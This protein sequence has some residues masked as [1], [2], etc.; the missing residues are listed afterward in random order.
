MP[1]P[2]PF[3]YRLPISLNNHLQYPK[4][5][6]LLTLIIVLLCT[7]CICTFST[8]PP[9]PTSLLVRTSLSSLSSAHYLSPS[10]LYQFPF[11]QIFSFI[12]IMLCGNATLLIL[13][14]LSFSFLSSRRTPMNAFRLIKVLASICIIFSFEPG[15]ENMFGFKRWD[16]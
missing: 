3:P 14:L 6:I 13:F 1:S 7:W 15:W 9:H 12:F 10:S 2:N 16:V 5:L 4:T 8:F 11:F